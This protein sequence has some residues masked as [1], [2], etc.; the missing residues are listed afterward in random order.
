M[1]MYKLV[2]KI[3]IPCDFFDVEAWK[4]ENRLVAKTFLNGSKVSTV[5]LGIEHGFDKECP[6]L[7]E[8]MVFGGTLDGEQD[9]YCTYDE[10]V[11][12]HKAMVQRVKDG[13]TEG[14]D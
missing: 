8:T 11:S 13:L 14:G 3:P 12:G 4:I 5:F 9:R 7:F 10:A 2:G 6:I 1:H